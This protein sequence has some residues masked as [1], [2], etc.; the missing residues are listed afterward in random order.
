MRK[1]A[2]YGILLLVVIFGVLPLWG[3]DAYLVFPFDDKTGQNLSDEARSAFS[4]ALY[5][6]GRGD[7]IPYYLRSPMVQRLIA[8]GSLTEAEVTSIPTDA[9][10]AVQIGKL[11]GATYVFLG[12]IEDLKEEEGVITVM[13]KAQMFSVAEGKQVKE[14][15]VSGKS[16]GKVNGVSREAAIKEALDDAGRSLATALVGEAKQPVKPAEVKRKERTTYYTLGALILGWVIL[17][18][19]RE[20]GGGP[21][22]YGVQVNAVPSGASVDVSWTSA[23]SGVARYSV[24]RASLQNTAQGAP[25]NIAAISDVKGLPYEELWEVSAPQTLYTDMDVRIGNAYYY[26]V[27]ALG[28]AGEEVT[29]GYSGLV[30]VGA[31]ATPT[32]VTAVKISSQTQSYVQVDWQ[33]VAGASSY[34]VYRSASQNGP[35]ELIGT[36]TGTE[37][38]DTN[39]LSGTCY[40]KVSALSSQGAEGLASAPVQPTIEPGP[41][42]SP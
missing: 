11:L 42:P 10:R 1:A 37:Y 21:T 36:S 13:E 7:V 26:C 9:D 35:Y 30:I 40:Y 8:D 6:T 38:M 20:K 3:K 22:V 33:A 32:N 2:Q 16:R 5:A 23:G 31:P 34:R 17:N 4:I 25:W 41:P 15:V 27:V 12:S 14:A 39:P 24:Q 18:Q 29:R 19:T 28:K